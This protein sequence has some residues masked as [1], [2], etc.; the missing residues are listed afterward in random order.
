[1]KLTPDFFDYSCESYADSQ[2]LSGELD[3][4]LGLQI[5]AI[6]NEL[7]FNAKQS[8]P[9]GSVKS[10]GPQMHAGAQSWVGLKPEQLQT[11][12]DELVEIVRYINP[13]GPQT[14][15]DL[16]AGYGRLGLV[17]HA[18]RPEI[19]FIGHEIVKERVNEGNRIFSKWGI[20]NA[21]LYCQNLM[22]D[23]FQLPTAKCY[24]I[25]DY[26]KMEH[27]KKTLQQL[28]DQVTTSFHLVARGRVRDFIHYH[29][30]WLTVER[31]H[32]TDTYSIY[33]YQ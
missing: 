5:H 21:H 14:W 1:M 9:D 3:I 10:W 13:L 28:S 32:H 30:P 33:S 22:D 16:G 25:Y 24:F 11:N 18:M 27:M 8:S 31:P 6:E 23:N 26:G 20:K 29:H 7:V 15:L 12:Y 4:K 2:K 19:N 17:L